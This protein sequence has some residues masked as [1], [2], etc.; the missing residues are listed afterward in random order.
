MPEALEAML[1]ITAP[2]WFI[3]GGFVIMGFVDLWKERRYDD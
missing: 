3:A 2:V 1:Y